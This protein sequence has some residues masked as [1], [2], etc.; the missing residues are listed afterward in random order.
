MVPVEK[1]RK[2]NIQRFDIV[3][4]MLFIDCYYQK[5]DCGHRLYELSKQHGPSKFIKLIESFGEKKRRS[6]GII[7]GFKKGYLPI[8][9]DYYLNG[10]GTHR[11]ACCL[12]FN[13]KSVPVKI[14]EKQYKYA[15]HRGLK[16]LQDTYCEKDIEKI[17]DF[18]CNLHFAKLE[19][20]K[21]RIN[22]LLNIHYDDTKIN[23]VNE[24]NNLIFTANSDD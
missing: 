18:Y 6:N 12:H 22:Y 4:N 10:D 14:I 20:V 11:L 9:E 8:T 16:W 2:A 15:A 1:L 5:N 3:V 24:Y 21:N 19:K 7:V 23:N 17:V 13:I